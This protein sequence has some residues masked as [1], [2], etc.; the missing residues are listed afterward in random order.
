M[1][2][3]SVLAIGLVAVMSL[4][5][6][7]G[8]GGGEKEAAKTKDG[9]VELELLS[10]KSESK[11]T[12]QKLVDKFNESQDKIVVNLNQPAD[13]GTVLKTRMTKDD[14]P[15]M[16]A[17]GG[18]STY[19]ELQGAGVLADLTGA[20]FLANINESY[21]EMLYAMNKDQEAKCYGVPYATNSSGII[22]N[23]T[24]FEENGVEVPETWTEL[25]EVCE[26]LKAAG[27]TPFELTFKDAWTILPAWNSMAPVLQPENF[28]VDKKAGEA[29]FAGTHEELLEKY[30]QLIPYAQADFMGTSYDDGNK[31]FA[32]G[33]AAMMINGCWAITEITKANADVKVDQFAFPSSDDADANLVTSGVDVLLGV[34]TS[35]ADAEAAKEFIAFMCEAENAQQYIDEQFAFSAVT[36]VEQKSETVAGVQADITAG[37]VAD[38]PDHYYVSGLDLAADLSSFFLEMNNG[39]DLTQNIADTLAKIDTDYDTLNVN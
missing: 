18:D 24:I 39:K 13:A 12:V 27:V 10:T 2:K 21:M 25:L 23:K 7:T 11:E 26:T 4:G 33:S 20:E 37:K 1:K 32:A 8:C 5:M 19:S 36:G 14:L 38:Y 15:D 17:M 29:T 28:Y 6:L 22:Y 9:K 30:A 35:C 16:V 34:T 3:R 31:N